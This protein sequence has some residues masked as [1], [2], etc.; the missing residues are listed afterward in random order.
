MLR[1]GNATRPLKDKLDGKSNGPKRGRKPNE[2][3]LKAAVRTEQIFPG[4]FPRELCVLSHTRPVWR[5]EKNRAVIVA[6]EVW[7]HKP[8]KTYGKI[9]GVIGRNGYGLAFILAVAYQVYALGLSLDK[10][11]C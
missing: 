7:M 3:K 10:V 8:T 6:Y 2:A 1:G 11:V 5:L 9:P 4:N